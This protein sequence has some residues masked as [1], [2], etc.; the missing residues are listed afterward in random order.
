MFYTFT[1]FLLLSISTNATSEPE[2]GSLECPS[3]RTSLVLHSE[4]KLVEQ[5]I[6]P[7]SGRSHMYFTL[8]FFLDVDLL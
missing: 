2:Y 1:L 7:K 8:I 3:D 6:E 5:G 4:L